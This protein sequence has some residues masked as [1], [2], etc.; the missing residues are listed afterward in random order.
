MDKWNMT[1]Q[2]EVDWILQRLHQVS[3]QQNRICEQ[4]GKCINAKMKLCMS[5]GKSTDIL[6]K[7]IE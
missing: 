2:K 3:E 6:N 1:K 5:T 4:K 7:Q